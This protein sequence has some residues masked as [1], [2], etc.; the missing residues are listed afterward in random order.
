LR[1][2]K[3]N[4]YSAMRKLISSFL[5]LAIVI[6][7]EA[8]TNKTDL[9]QNLEKSQPE[10]QDG[11]ITATLTSS[12]RL[13]GEKDDLTNVIQIIPSG[14]TVTVIDSDSTYLHV[15][16]EEN[17]GYIFKRHAV[18]N[19]LPENSDIQ[20][21][22][23]QEVQQTQPVQESQPEQEQ[24]VS[25]FTFL[26][27]KYGTNMAAKLMAGKIWKGMYAEM[28]KDSWGRAEKI[29]RIVR[30]D[31]TKEEWIFKNTWLYFENNI[32]VEWGPIR[33]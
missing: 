13:F 23:Q 8:Q 12:T 19:P 3:V 18:I 4:N 11:T 31:I 32:L 28:V 1:Y 17:E 14:S 6:V 27:N 9:L 5:F 16:F 20:A 30:G 29:N 26:E 10:N 2:Q 24:Q 22:P 21:Q 25:R 33:N 7:A 15:V